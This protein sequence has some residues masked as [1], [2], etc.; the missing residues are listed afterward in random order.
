M[1]G[2]VAGFERHHGHLTLD[3]IDLR[4]I[5]RDCGTPC[6]VYS[7]A[8]L[9][10]R[11]RALDTAFAG[12]PH[13]IHY[14]L[15]ANSTLGLVEVLRR[16]GAA[17]DVNSG[18]ELEV[19]LAAG[20]A[21]S[22]IVFT[23]VG[24]TREEITRAVELGVA[25]LNAESFGEVDRIA[26]IASSLG[27][28]ANIALR[29]N[30]DVEAGTH[31]HIA[32]GAHTTKFGVSLDEAR[33]MLR[34]VARHDALRVVGLHVH[35]GSQIT[36]VEPFAEGVAVVAAFAAEL[37]RDGVPLQHID[38]GGGLGIPYRE[39]ESVVSPEAYAEAVVPIIRGT[40]LT[41]LLEPG[42]WIVAPAGVLLAQVVD[43]KVRS[44][45]TKFVIIDAG[46]TDLLR[47]ALYDAWHAVEPLV[48]RP[49]QAESVDVVGP[50][51]ETTD[52]FAHNRPLPPLEVGDIV[53]IRD[54]GAYGSV[55]ASN[56]NRRPLAPEV[57]IESGRP[58]VIRRRQTVDEMLQWER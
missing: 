10:E 6:H 37:L 25:A 14:A 22:E 2:S 17:A 8:M 45:K 47:P 27:R 53:A 7:A 31:R 20:F 15:K 32:T 43:V 50:V 42:R 54:T 51:C 1:R 29:I 5:A 26:A 18:G 55:M 21:P 3:G 40:K 36:Q 44:E 9:A 52:T 16:Q 11:F 35:V 39:G 28:T 57:L 33:A 4:D 58:R 12:V 24:K 41:V 34:D 30:P 56:Y 19:A 23:G 13:R 38:I 46:M 48:V 49:G